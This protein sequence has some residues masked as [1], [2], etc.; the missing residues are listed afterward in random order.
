MP[1]TI[2]KTS[3]QTCIALCFTSMARIKLLKKIYGNRRST[4]TFLYI[5]LQVLYKTRK[6]RCT[7]PINSFE[8][9]LFL[10]N[11]SAQIIHT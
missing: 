6:M 11:V 7:V 4:E 9:P 2:F 1:A 10:G 3:I 5:F 8:M